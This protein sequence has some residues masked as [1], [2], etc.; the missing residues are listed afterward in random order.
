MNS[1]AVWVQPLASPLFWG[2]LPPATAFPGAVSIHT[3]A[4]GNLLPPKLTGSLG[5][6]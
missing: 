1:R 4:E 6:Q 2:H 5:Q 3:Q